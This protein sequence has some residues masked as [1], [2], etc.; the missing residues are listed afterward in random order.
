M[1][2]D[3]KKFK[4]NG[5]ITLENTFDLATF[6]LV[7]RI[8]IQLKKEYAN[9]RLLGSAKPFGVPTYWKGVDMASK[10]STKL[11]ELYTSKVMTYI[12][13]ILL[14]TKTVYLFND[15][16][17]V[18]QPKENFTFEKH[19]DNQYGP[20]PEMALDN[21]FKTITCCWVL[22]DFSKNNG[23]ITFFHQNGQVITPLPKAGSL[24]I[25]D[26]NLV[27]SSSRNNTNNAR[28]VWLNIYSNVDIQKVPT[29][30]PF[31]KNFYNTKVSF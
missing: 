29:Q 8:S 13:S 26:G 12:A 22:D 11:Y 9:E 7:K 19:F 15:Q 30:K 3:I 23:P 21:K 25:W 16:V 10:Y 20:N 17:V 27:H 18:K 6:E 1:K 31:F 4:E 24:L 2:I 28:C 14:E 5:F